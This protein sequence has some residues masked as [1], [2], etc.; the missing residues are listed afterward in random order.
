M[1]THRHQRIEM[2]VDD[3]GTFLMIPDIRVQC[4]PLQRAPR[5]TPRLLIAAYS[6]LH[7]LLH[8]I[9]TAHLRDEL[10]L[11]ILVTTYYLLRAT[12]TYYLLLTT[13]YLIHAT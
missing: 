3:L 8:A 7:A 13:Y 9:F 1:L 10:T 2:V 6:C 4:A 12:F 5:V 11:I